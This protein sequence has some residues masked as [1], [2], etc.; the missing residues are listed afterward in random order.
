M[1][2]LVC[3]KIKIV[4]AFFK[5]I[6]TSRQAGRR[7]KTFA[8][9]KTHTLKLNLAP[10]PRGA[11]RRRRQPALDPTD[12][13]ELIGLTVRRR[14]GRVGRDFKVWRGTQLCKKKRICF[15]AGAISYFGYIFVILGSSPLKKTKNKISYNLFLICICEFPACACF[16]QVR[17]FFC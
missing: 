9:F 14:G 12:W 10:P 2:F 7:V 16:L 4:C 3:P 5:Q 8:T 15:C 6:Q 13:D 17:Y 11:L 1:L